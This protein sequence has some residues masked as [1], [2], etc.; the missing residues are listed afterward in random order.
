MPTD[1]IAAALIRE[2]RDIDAGIEQFIARLGKAGGVST[3]FSTGGAPSDVEAREAI[4]ALLSAF[5]ALRRHIYLEEEFIFPSLSDPSVA[6]AIMV[7]YREHGQIWRLMDQA[8]QLIDANGPSSESLDVCRSMLAEL[9]RHNAKEEP[10]IYPHTD[11]DLDPAERAR[12]DEFLTSGAMPSGWVCRD[13]AANT[14]AKKL[15]F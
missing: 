10:I 1:S 8:E 3:E 6:M 5:S 11:S 4:S 14:G 13:A 15:P 9:E 12:L 7:M 2:H